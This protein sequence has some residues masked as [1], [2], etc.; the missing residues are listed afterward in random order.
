MADTTGLASCW[1]LL[2]KTPSSL[3]CTANIQPTTKTSQGQDLGVG[4]V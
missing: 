1:A 2:P 4:K 3:A